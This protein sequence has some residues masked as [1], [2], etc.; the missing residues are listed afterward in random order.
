MDVT[1]GGRIV[2]GGVRLWPVNT[3]IGKEE[4][5]R[6]LRL[7]VPDLAAGETW[8]AG[9]CHFPGYGKEF[10]D[11]LC[12]EQL[13]THTIAGRTTTKWEK[14]RDRNEALDCRIYA[15]AAAAVLR[16]EVFPEKR[17][18]E[19]EAA[20]RAGAA[21]GAAR[22]SAITNKGGTPMPQYRP[23]GGNSESFLE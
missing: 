13:I 14:R 1:A 11:Q 5:Y 22:A 15:R 19:M 9:F 16:M 4:L 20:L 2:K 6:S 10:F 17:W 23:L 7:G 21:S 3:S 8:P 18:D 12:A